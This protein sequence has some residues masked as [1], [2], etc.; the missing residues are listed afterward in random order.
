[1]TVVR[2]ERPE[3]VPDIHRVNEL[4]FGQP[5]EAKLV[6]FQFEVRDQHEVI[7]RGLHKRAVITVESFARRVAKKAK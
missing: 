5:A 7:A 2:K 3:D 4:A 6:D 1:M